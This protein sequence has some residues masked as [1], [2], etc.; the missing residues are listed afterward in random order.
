MAATERRRPTMTDVAQLAGVSLKTVS[1]VVNGV[2]T[3]D[4]A[5]ADRV[6]AAAAELGFRPNQMAATLKS[7]AATAMIGLV[8]KDIS[9]E[10]YA[11]ITQGAAE[12]AASRNVQLITSSS[13]GEDVTDESELATIFELCRRRADGLI[14]VPRGHDQSMLEREIQMGTPMVFVDRA[15]VGLAAD[16]IIID[17]VGGAANAISALVDAGHHRIGMIFDSLDIA[18]LRSRYEG[19]HDELRRRGLTTDA[20]LVRTDAHGP[21]ASARAVAELLDANSPPSAIFC[22][23]NRATIGAVE[24]V[25]RRRAATAIAGFD[26]F[27]LA[28][29]MPVPLTLVS[30]DA[31]ELGRIAASMLFERIDGYQGPARNRTLPVHLRVSGTQTLTTGSGS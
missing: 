28:H 20:A 12:I 6:S 18:T 8:I 23:N 2:T 27:H 9:N 30:Y 29:L 17:N 5:M 21:E 3:V 16:T 13:T 26:D 15:P 22:G 24:E 25:W 11:S 31:T 4:P 7:G 19:A 14:I 10:F 1:R